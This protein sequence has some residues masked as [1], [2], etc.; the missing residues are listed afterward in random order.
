MTGLPTL[1]QRSLLTAVRHTILGLAHS[2]KLVAQSWLDTSK[3]LGQY[4]YH[5]AAR[6]AIRSA[7]S[8]GLNSEQILLQE[9]SILKDS[10][11]AYKALLMLEPVEIDVKAL[12]AKI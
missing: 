1:T 3:A 4:G 11:Q 10:G 8:C 5:E 9:C 2:P 12:S 6:N 7:E